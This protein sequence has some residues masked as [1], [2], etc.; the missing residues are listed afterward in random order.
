MHR[1]IRNER[2]KHSLASLRF[3]FIRWAVRLEIDVDGNL[4]GAAS[5]ARVMRHSP[6]RGLEPVC[7]AEMHVRDE[8]V[9]VEGLALWSW[10]CARMLFTPHYLPCLYSTYTSSGFTQTKLTHTSKDKAWFPIFATDGELKIK[11][12]IEK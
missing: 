4:V 2:E 8:H 9:F 6:C 7:V 1:C 10:D 3:R 5:D 12:T 11:S